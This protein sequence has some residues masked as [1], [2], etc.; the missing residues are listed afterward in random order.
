MPETTTPAESRADT[1]RRH[2]AT[3]RNNVQAREAIAAGFELI[4]E[5]MTPCE[6][7]GNPS[8][9]DLHDAMVP[10][11]EKTTGQAA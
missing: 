9:Q 4:A 11:A 6:D 7:C 3:I 2:A 8:L 1:L 10:D 5:A